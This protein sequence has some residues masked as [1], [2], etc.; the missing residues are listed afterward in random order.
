MSSDPQESLSVSAASALSRDRSKVTSPD[1][2]FGPNELATQMPHVLLSLLERRYLSPLHPEHW[3]FEL[4]TIDAHRPLLREV[5]RLG[6]P[7]PG[8]WAKVMPHLL[9]ACHEPGHSLIMALHGHEGRN[10]IY[11]GCRRL[12]G[13]RSTEDYLAAQESALRAFFVGL[14]LGADVARLDSAGLPEMA[15]LAQS[16]P[17]MAAMTGIASGRQEDGSPA[18]SQ[19]FDRLIEAVGTHNY[20]LMVVAEPADA[21]KIDTTLDRL[22]HLKSEIHSYTRRSVN[23]GKSLTDGSSRTE[24]A[25]ET[26][27]SLLPIFFFAASGFLQLAGVPFHLSEGLWKV[28]GEAIGSAAPGMTSI[29]WGLNTLAGREEARRN[30]LNRQMSSSITDTDSATTELLDAN[31]EFCEELLDQHIGRLQEGRGNGLWQTSIYIASESEAGLQSVGAALRSTCSGRSSRLDPLRLHILPAH[32]LRP[33]LESGRVLQ[34]IPTDEKNTFEAHPLGSSFD[35]L[36]TCLNSRELSVLVNMPA[37]E[38]AG[39]P[40]RDHA[41]FALSVPAADAQEIPLGHLL[42]LGGRPIDTVSISRA[43]LNRHVFVT[44]MTGYGKSNT[45]MALLVEAYRRF[46][47]PFLV[48]EPAKA[49]Y[50]RLSCIPELRDKLR[51]FAVGGKSSTPLRLNPLSPLSGVPLGRHIDLL[52][53]VFNASFPMF[54]GMA[55]VLEEAIH[56]VYQERG[57]SLYTSENP[58][59][60]L[61]AEADGKWALIPSLQDLHDQI[62]VVLKRKNYGPEVHQNMG[63]ALR[64]RLHSLMVGNKGLMLNTRRSIPPEDLF[65]NPTIIELQN[66]G[67]DEEKAFVMALLFVFLYEFAE[68]RQGW[69]GPSQRGKLQHVTLIEEAHRLL[70]ATP[71]VS[72]SE[73]GDPRGKAVTMFTDMLAEMRAYG[74]GFIIADQSPTKLVSDT[75]KNTNLKIIHRLSH[76]D[77][78]TAA[79]GC[80]NLTHEQ[81]RHLNNLPPG[82]AV[83]HDERIGEA[84]LVQV[85]Q[86]K[87][88]TDS[89]EQLPT[90]NPSARPVIS[91]ATYLYRH[92]GCRSCPKPC[93]FLPLVHDFQLVE[94]HQTHLDAFL[95]CILF[96]DFE[97]AVTSWAPLRKAISIEVT[98]FDG[99]DGPL[100]CAVLA[101]MER[102]LEDLMNAGLDGGHL[103]PQARLRREAALKNTGELLRRWIGSDVPSGDYLGDL[104][105]VEATLAGCAERQPIN[106]DAKRDCPG[107]S[108]DC[109]TFRFVSPRL[110]DLEKLF[111]NRVLGSLKTNTD[112]LLNSLYNLA[113]PS[114]PLL[115]RHTKK[116]RIKNT[117]M[118]CL[119]GNIPMPP[120]TQSKKVDLMA[121][122]SASLSGK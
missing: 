53:A 91:N 117:V 119:I 98:N 27:T 116:L 62:D 80:V 16:A 72:T 61:H 25:G 104:R 36:A 8:E 90:A 13:G 12:G 66:M 78:R 20:L 22:R 109:V 50:R 96:A 19:S 31:A 42:D 82:Q 102:W 59:L 5:T 52:K 39:V 87:D 17:A 68:V 103:S 15:W 26:S 100:F 118:R 49:E 14:K 84:V 11:L 94:R 79:G 4:P 88:V 111:V 69:V 93:A 44:G 73:I 92:S 71:G 67:D 41:A 29:G 35:S 47:V 85:L 38:I 9:T 21:Q 37:K 1:A 110:K 58:H 55:P 2:L 63:A 101:R 64:S 75:L 18:A 108:G 74:E 23:R 107:C 115:S 81:M 51:V 60:D 43:T 114:I 120:A 57:W 83:V 48:V 56:D 112:E 28:A 121:A 65:G 30:R 106:D 105:S 86:F 99:G 89:D 7:E 34:M 113:L 122:L 77:D 97:E 45:C 24:V 76:P 70:K 3:R 54:A 6:R 95:E 33:A 40:M 46:G 32:V 10:R